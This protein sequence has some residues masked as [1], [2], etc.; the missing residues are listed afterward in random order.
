MQLK[1]AKINNGSE[2]VIADQTFGGAV[3]NW[4][5]VGAARFVAK[6]LGIEFSPGETMKTLRERA[7]AAGK[8]E[9]VKT[10][11]TAYDL[12]LGVYYRTSRNV[13]A[14]AAANPEMRTSVR[15][16]FSSKGVFSGVDT[17]SR[18]VKAPAVKKE[19]ALE[20]ALAR[21]AELESKL[22]AAA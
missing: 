5:P 15:P 9:L 1:L 21:I 17:K 3:A 2:L 6:E 19:S 16:K 18:I 22:V 14:L 11:R 12:A 10:A 13:A 7:E 20:V 4:K 8:S